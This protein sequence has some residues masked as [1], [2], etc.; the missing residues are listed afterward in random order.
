ML[1]GVTYTLAYRWN[2]TDGHWYLQVLDEPGQVLLAGDCRVVADWPLYS[3]HTARTPPGFLIVLDTT[4]QQQD[5][6]LADLGGRHQLF[7]VLASEVGA[8]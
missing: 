5:P 7:Y 2:D 8:G 1:D 3:A 6:G 4:G